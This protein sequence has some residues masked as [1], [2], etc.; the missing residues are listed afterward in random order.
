[1]RRFVLATA[2]ILLSGAPAF[3]HAHLNGSTPAANATL[4]SAPSEVAL[5]FSE[6]IEP[7]FSSI[8]V[9]DAKG[10]RV[11]ANDA[12]IAAGNAKQLVVSLKSLAA[13]SYE[14]DWKATSV[15][16]HKT[17]GSF[18]FRIKP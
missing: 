9:K 15:D 1:M 3:A 18:S 16:T 10:T 12:H 11:D 7:K 6:E 5:N 8:V 17:S 2:L 4:S 14:V 13:G